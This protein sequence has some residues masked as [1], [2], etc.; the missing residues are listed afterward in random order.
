MPAE[1]IIKKYPNRRLYDTEESRYITLAEIKAMVMNDTGFKVLDSQTEQDITRNIL[2]QIIVEQEAGGQPLFTS[3]ML[4][5]FIRFYG[6]PAQAALSSFLEQGLDMLLQQQRALNEQVQGT[7]TN[8]M[9]YW[10]TIGQQNMDLWNRMGA[11]YRESQ[12]KKPDGDNKP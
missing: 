5:R 3:S 1:R 12:D 4:E 8:P 9:E 7:W 6:D 11:L 2:L 10:T